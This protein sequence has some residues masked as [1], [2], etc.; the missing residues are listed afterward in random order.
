MNRLTNITHITPSMCYRRRVARVEHIER[1]S[2]YSGRGSGLELIA[3]GDRMRHASWMPETSVMT[4][5][6]AGQTGNGSRASRLRVRRSH[7]K[8]VHGERMDLL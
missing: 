4:C 1:R 7:D 5:V 6:R 3:A 8:N 2:P